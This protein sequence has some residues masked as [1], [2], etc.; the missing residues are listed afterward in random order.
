MHSSLPDS[1]KKNIQKYLSRFSD[2][3]NIQYCFDCTF[4]NV[5]VVPLYK[6]HKNI[7]NQ[8]NNLVK[9]TLNKLPTLIIYVINQP[10]TL[11]Q[12]KL[13]NKKTHE[14]ID[15]CGDLKFKN[16]EY[17]IV[18]NHNLTILALDE[19]TQPLGHSKGVGLAR[20]I[21]SDTA[22]NLY[23]ENNIDSH[24]FFS[25]D[26][27]TLFP[28]DYFDE[29]CDDLAVSFISKNYIHDHSELSDSS[30]IAAIQAYDWYLRYYV[31]MMKKIGSNFCFHTIGSSFVVS[32]PY[33]ANVRGFPQK[34]A[35]EDFYLVNKLAKLAEFKTSDLDPIVIKARVSDRVPFGTGPSI[36]TI[37]RELRD[38]QPYFIFS[39]DAFEEIGLVISVAN[40]FLLS[41][42]KTIENLG[43]L[44]NYPRIQKQLERAKLSSRNPQICRKSFFDWFDGFRQR[45]LLNELSKSSHPMVDQKVLSKKINL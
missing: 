11:E 27:D 38:D 2:H 24:F 29:K 40:D 43:L 41:S 32:F 26:G 8:I 15:T 4:K 3:K 1:F 25:S 9:I 39:P 10:T 45:Q 7:K 13:W 33:Y 44:E 16:Q 17:S 42:E 20:K 34:Q 18:K 22:L 23:L 36:K 12:D 37:S 21:G 5:L 14:I 19:Y 28:D 30:E 31:T 6:E 35:G